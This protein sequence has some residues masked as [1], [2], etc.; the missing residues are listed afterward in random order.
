MSLILLAVSHDQRFI[1][2]LLIV[3][4]KQDTEPTTD[5]RGGCDPGRDREA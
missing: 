4:E 1:R 2:S 5:G 3:M